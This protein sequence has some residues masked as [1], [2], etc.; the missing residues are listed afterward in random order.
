MA[1]MPDSSDEVSDIIIGIV[2]PC[3]AGKSTLVKSLRAQGY[4]GKQIAQEHSFVQNM[5]RRITNP[6]Y[7]V[8]LHVSFSKALE[9]RKMDWN[10]KDY[11][12][13]LRR[14]EHAREHADLYILTDDLSP[15]QV[16]ER[17][18]TFLQST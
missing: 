15:E 8:Y 12:E 16:L 1:L 18:I 10:I 9:R 13:Q 2:G 5:W 4:W 6:D 11:E 17:V 3:K 7:L 14:L